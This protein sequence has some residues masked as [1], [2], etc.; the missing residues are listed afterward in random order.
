MYALAE[1]S[2]QNTKQFSKYKISFQNT[3]PDF[4]AQI[5]FQ[6]TNLILKTQITIQILKISFQI[7]NTFNYKSVKLGFPLVMSSLFNV[8]PKFNIKF[9][10]CMFKQFTI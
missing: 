7:V 3:K 2:L 9:C 8:P 4:K 10:R 6:N 1:T 5:S